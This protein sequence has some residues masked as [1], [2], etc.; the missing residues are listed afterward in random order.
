M[1]RDAELRSNGGGHW[2]R[3]DPILRNWTLK[4]RHLWGV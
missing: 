1:L 4:P 3:C 2:R